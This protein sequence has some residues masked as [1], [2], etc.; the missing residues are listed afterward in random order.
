VRQILEKT[1]E[2]CLETFHIFVDFRAAYDTVDRNKLYGALQEFRIPNNLINLTKLTM[3]NIICNVRI[4]NDI[5]DDFNTVNGL[6]QGDG[7]ACLLF[8]IALEKVIR[9]A[10][11]QMNGTIFNKSVQ[12]LA[13]ADDIEA[14]KSIQEA[15]KTMGLRVNMEKTKFMPVS[16]HNGP[17]AYPA[18][19][20]DI[21]EVDEFVYLGSPVNKINNVTDEIHRR[22][23]NAH[24][25]FYGLHAQLKSKRISRK[26]KIR[27]YKTLVRPVLVY[28][29]E[30]W[31]LSVAD[32]EKLR[33]FERKVLRK[34]I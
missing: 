33:V 30:S 7:L 1:S 4:Q 21:E 19:E 22:I 8:N 14:F 5:S 26:T 10:Q 23:I 9:D 18:D 15:A 11:I 17:Q 31:P 29:S 32:S 24:R 27:L 2:F 20:Q 28:G 6:R 16:T 3:K 12:I 34:I 25:C 13:Y